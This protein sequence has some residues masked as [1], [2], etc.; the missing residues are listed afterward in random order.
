MLQFAMRK[1]RLKVGDFGF[2]LS[3]GMPH[4]IELRFVNDILLFA[5]SAMEIGKLL[6]SLVAELSEVRLLFFFFNADNVNVNVNP[7]C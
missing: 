2:G 7:V 5:R 3:D 4:L 1:W 6:D